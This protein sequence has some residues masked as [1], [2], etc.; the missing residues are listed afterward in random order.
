MVNLWSS[1]LGFLSATDLDLSLFGPEILGSDLDNRQVF[2]GFADVVGA[3]TATVEGL[4]ALAGVETDA[5]G[6]V[7]VEEQV[8]SWVLT[9]GLGW[10]ISL[11]LAEDLVDLG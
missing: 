5:V 8:I 1:E 4:V 10:V 6:L 2:V 9:E 11:V 7:V 3:D